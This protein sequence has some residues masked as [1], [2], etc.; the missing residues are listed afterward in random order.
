[1]VSNTDIIYGRNPVLEALRFGNIRIEKIYIRFGS[2]GTQIDRIL[3]I[4]R[5]NDIPCS[6]V[7]KNKFKRLEQEFGKQEQTQGVIAF[8]SPINYLE[9]EELIQVAFSRQENPILLFLDRI[10]DPQNLG[11]I[12]RTS[13]CAGVGGLIL[14]MKE[15]APV[16][17]TV[18]KASAGGI[19]NLPV[20]RVSSSSQAFEFLK[21]K[22]F[23]VVGTA[24]AGGKI[25]TQGIYDQ[26]VV[27]AIGSEG[28]GLSKT[29]LKHCDYI[30]EIPVFGK[31][32]SL[33]ASVSAGI[34]LYE[35][36]RQRGS[37]GSK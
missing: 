11:A 3:Q 18:I 34:I 4:A 24:P 2:K 6:I 36:L 33:N 12:A 8:I 17:A 15:T 26:P 31:V 20:A 28:K 30:V 14:T 13:E 7:E 1:M 35:I 23:W 22:G 27:V 10:Q 16:N 9:V 29:V 37:F 25:Y 21:S 32:G 19:L 5:K